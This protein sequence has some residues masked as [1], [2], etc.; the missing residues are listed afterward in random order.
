MGACVP[1]SSPGTRF[2]M[3]LCCH[4]CGIDW[5]YR[6]IP[7]TRVL[8]LTHHMMMNHHFHGIGH[9]CDRFLGYQFAEDI[10][11]VTHHIIR[12]DLFLSQVITHLTGSINYAVQ[13]HTYFGR[14][15]SALLLPLVQAVSAITGYYCVHSLFD[16]TLCDH[17]CQRYCPCIV[18]SLSA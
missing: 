16:A 9:V 17:S 6:K 8:C 4:G 18:H 7:S 14:A 2:C 3:L 5:C 10:H 13:R 15:V 1:R 11:T 12:F